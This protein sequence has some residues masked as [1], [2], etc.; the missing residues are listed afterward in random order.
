M[1]L[2][3]D[4]HESVDNWPEAVVAVALLAFIAFTMWIMFRD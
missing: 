3:A 1:F 2:L 4:I